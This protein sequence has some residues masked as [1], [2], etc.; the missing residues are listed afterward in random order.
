M[1]PNDPDE[2]ATDS[3]E[4][5]PGEAVFKEAKDVLYTDTTFSLDLPP[6]PPLE[7]FSIEHW[8][9][10]AAKSM[11][12]PPPD[13]LAPFPM[14][15]RSGSELHADLERWELVE[16]TEVAPDFAD[17]L[18]VLAH[19]HTFALWGAARFPARTHERT[20]DLPDEAREWGLPTH[21][22]VCPRVPFLITWTRKGMCVAATST[23][24][25]M[26]ISTA[27]AHGSPVADMANALWAILDPDD[28]WRAREMNTVRYPRELIDDLAEN[29]ATGSTAFDGTAEDR[30]KALKSVLGQHVV[31]SDTRT[32]LSELM[33]TQPAAIVQALA[34]VRDTDGTV[35]TPLKSTVGLIFAAD[36]R[37]GVVCVSSPSTSYGS[38]SVVYEPGTRKA[39]LNALQDLFK[40]A[41]HR[42]HGGAPTSPDPIP[43]TE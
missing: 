15:R 36:D 8:L 5:S 4:D 24:D 35:F 23:E 39:V 11:V 7:R 21:A 26:N 14:P 10:L 30:D 38:R 25:G 28:Q 13:A 27:P 19:R 33:T 43:D 34:T 32:E 6:A 22:T 42:R 18:E 9:Y 40:D 31:G 20:Y 16:G 2:S 37:G 12:P 1:T 41:A 29:P 3:P 17:L